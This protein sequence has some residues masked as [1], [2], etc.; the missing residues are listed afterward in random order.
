MTQHEFEYWQ[1]VT[2]ESAHKW[3]E[4]RVTRLNGN[5]ALFYT[6]GEDGQYMRLSPEGKL[7]VGTYEGAIPHIGE[8]MFRRGAEHQYRIATPLLSSCKPRKA[9]PRGYVLAG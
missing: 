5:G 8:A 3:V 2:A 7:T 6:G 9:I 1:A 4:D